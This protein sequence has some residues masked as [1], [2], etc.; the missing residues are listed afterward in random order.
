MQLSPRQLEIFQMAFLLQSSRKTAD[1]LNISQPAVSRAIIDLE[2]V[3][4]FE[5][6]DRSGRGFAP[7]ASAELFHEAV[8]RHFNG[9]E[10]IFDAAKLIKAGA[11]GRLTIAALPIFA[12]T[13]VA[14]VIGCMMAENERLR[15]DLESVG[16]RGCIAALRAG[17]VD[18]AVVSA[19]FADS[20]F[21]ARK[22]GS[23]TAV[24]ALPLRDELAGETS[25]TL[26]MLAGAP[27]ITLTSD[28][29][30]RMAIE[31]AFR[32]AAL[33]LSIRAEVRTQAAISEMVVQG[34][35]RAIVDPAS[36]RSQAGSLCIRPMASKIG[37]DMWAVYLRRNE[38]APV[39]EQLIE[40][41]VAQL[42]A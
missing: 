40:G 24:V 5:L 14:K 28:S 42:A 26:A 3:I 16:E 2:A 15:M 11:H 9:L 30:F 19:P 27:L 23:V 39:V 37:W 10:R 41:L 31:A 38:R 7:T 8:D 4:G 29:P 33:P 36:C 25:I 12:D 20:E 1:A 18:V 21:A 17:R 35:G 34:A 22:V 32:S 6:F 13:S